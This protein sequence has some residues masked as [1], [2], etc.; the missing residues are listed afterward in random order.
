MKKL[1]FWKARTNHLSLVSLLV[2]E[3]GAIQIKIHMMLFSQLYIYTH[4]NI[5]IN[6]F[7]QLTFNICFMLGQC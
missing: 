6:L 4:L 2:K 5:G 1:S 3:K 7:L